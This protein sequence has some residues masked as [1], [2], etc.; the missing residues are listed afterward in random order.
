MRVDLAAKAHQ[1][2]QQQQQ[3]QSPPPYAHAPVLFGF[4]GD[5]FVH[6]TQSR[7]LGLDYRG[8]NINRLQ[9]GR[10]ERSHSLMIVLRK[11]V[12]RAQSYARAMST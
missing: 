9:F 11:K 4:H 1:S 8:W 12:F 7:K 3:Q 6:S 5:D 10:T 2:K